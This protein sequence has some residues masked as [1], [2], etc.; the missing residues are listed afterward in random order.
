MWRRRPLWAAA[1]VCFAL[2][3]VS[4]IAAIL[5]SGAFYAGA[6]VFSLAGLALLLAGATR[7]GDFR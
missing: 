5:V 3:V 6:A 7:P 4:Q 1:L 2:A